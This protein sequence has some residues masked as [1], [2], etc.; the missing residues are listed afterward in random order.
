MSNIWLQH[1]KATQKK[2][3]KLLLK[4]ILKIASRTYKKPTAWQKEI[5]KEME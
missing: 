1:V 5:A 3:P 2:Y 4:E